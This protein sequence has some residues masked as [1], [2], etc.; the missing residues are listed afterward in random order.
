QMADYGALARVTPGF[1]LLMTVALLAAM[2]LPGLGGF[3]AELHILI[4]G[5]E[6]WGWLMLLASFGV[7]ISAAYA[8]RIMGQLFTGPMRPA[9]SE[10]HDVQPHEWVAALPLAAGLVILGLHPAP[11]IALIS[12]TVK[13]LAAI[14]TYSL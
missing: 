5:F 7:L 12:A 9:M 3:M 14:F 4:G 8:I 2:G 13:E 6:R 10:L 11:V 1:S